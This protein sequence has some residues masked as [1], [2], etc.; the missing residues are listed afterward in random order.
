MPKRETTKIGQ[1]LRRAR[2]AA[3]LSQGEVSR[4]TG[5]SVGQI[6]QVEGGVRASPAFAT[7]QRIAAALHVSMDDLLPCPE[8]RLSAFPESAR[9]RLA[10]RREVA[11]L[12]TD[13]MVTL[14]RIDEILARLDGEDA[15]HGT[16]RRKR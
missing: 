15:T 9:D 5:M 11:A 2:E 7:V 1:A 4:L 8:A 6:S 3:G 14:R 13:V 16:K 10:L 12:R